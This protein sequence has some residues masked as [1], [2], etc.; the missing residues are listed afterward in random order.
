MRNYYAPRR[1]SSDPCPAASTLLRRRGHHA[2]RCRGWCAS[3]GTVLRVSATA[4]S[5]AANPPGGGHHD[6]AMN[7]AARLRRHGRP[8]GIL[9]GWCPVRATNY[10][11]ARSVTLTRSPLGPS[12]HLGPS[13]AGTLHCAAMT[14]ALPAR[15]QYP[16]TPE[17]DPPA[18]SSADGFRFRAPLA[19]WVTAKDRSHPGRLDLSNR[20]FP[21]DEA[22]K[23]A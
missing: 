2:V 22:A 19:R 14:S 18:P 23:L 8:T 11:C 17:A 16:S 15:E 4:I 3:A 1:H 6:A 12:G 13:A 21:R 5:I 10:P 7:R 20:S 9:M